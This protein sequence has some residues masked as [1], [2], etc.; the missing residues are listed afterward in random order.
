MAKA[1]GAIEY[2][3]GDWTFPLAH[4][5]DAAPIGIGEQA[6]RQTVF[7]Q[8][9]QASWR[10]KQLLCAAGEPISNKARIFLEAASYRACDGRFGVCRARFWNVF[11]RFRTFRNL[12]RQRSIKGRSAEARAYADL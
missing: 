6:S 1:V 7:D 10:G 2:A 4:S 3:D 11:C 9:S 12:R 8:G 5:Q